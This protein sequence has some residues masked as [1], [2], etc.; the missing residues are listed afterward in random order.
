MELETP[1]IN[2]NWYYSFINKQTPGIKT[3]VP[4]VEE[5][6]GQTCS[7]GTVVSDVE[8]LSKDVSTLISAVEALHLAVKSL[9]Q[10]TAAKSAAMA[11]VDDV[12]TDVSSGQPK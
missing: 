11:V 9:P 8:R 12:L 3:C 5:T 6:M 7:I 10:T 2:Y 4:V 1:S